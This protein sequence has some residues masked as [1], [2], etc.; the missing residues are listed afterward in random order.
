MIHDSLAKKTV[1]FCCTRPPTP[2]EENWQGLPTPWLENVTAPTAP[3]S[4]EVTGKSLEMSPK[5]HHGI[6]DVLPMVSWI[7]FHD[8]TKPKLFE[9]LKFLG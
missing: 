1:A 5:K 3:G 9:S 6:G 2:P 8:L 4:Q 7:F